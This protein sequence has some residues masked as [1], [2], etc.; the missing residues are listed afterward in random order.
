MAK[1]VGS[2]L[3][4]LF[5]GAVVGA[6][7]GILFAPDEGK[8]TRKRLKESFDDATDKL[9]QKLDDLNQD[10]KHKKEKFKG[11]LEENVETLLSRS[12]YKAEEV[13]EILE[14]KLEQLKKAN[15]KLQK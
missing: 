9:R 2:V 13:I 6:G 8:K 5:V 14:K 3:T 7:V 15:A 12:S 4:A 10:F 1:G 11:S